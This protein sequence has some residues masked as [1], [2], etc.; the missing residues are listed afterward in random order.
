MSKHTHL[1]RLALVL[2]AHVSAR[3]PRT[4]PKWRMEGAQQQIVRFRESVKAAVTAA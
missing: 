2:D 4:L 1:A 3:A